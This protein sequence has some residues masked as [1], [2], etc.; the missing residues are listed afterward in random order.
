ML[1][2]STCCTTPRPHNAYVSQIKGQPCEMCASES[3]WNQYGVF[4][5]LLLNAACY[6]TSGD[7]Y[8]VA[9][10]LAHFGSQPGLEYLVNH[11]VKATAPV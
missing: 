5:L 11:D 10:D 7:A 8:C 4:C 3:K 6:L 1:L 2:R 9:C